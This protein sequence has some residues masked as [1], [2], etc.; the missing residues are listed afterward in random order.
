MRLEFHPEAL[1]EFEAA[2]QYYAQC[3]EG[4]DLRFISAVESALVQIQ[5]SPNRWRVLEDD[6][7]R[8]LTRIFPYAILYTVEPRYVLI[9]AVMH[10]HRKPGYWRHRL[11]ASE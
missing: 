5:E 1:A 9:I 3:Q 7:R 6:V 4:L 10:C 11:E 2:A 8:L